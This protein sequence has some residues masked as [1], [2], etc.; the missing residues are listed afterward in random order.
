MEVY[1]DKFEEFASAE[2]K[3]EIEEMPDIPNITS[4]QL[5]DKIIGSLIISAYRKLETQKGRTNGYYMLFMGYGRLLFRVFE[6]YFSIVVGL[7]EE[8]SQ[9]I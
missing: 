8:D 9:L 4:E 3:D 1:T 7:D 5:Q 6:S 2:L